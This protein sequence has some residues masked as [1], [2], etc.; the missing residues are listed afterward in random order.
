MRS[1]VGIPVVPAYSGTRKVRA[2]RMSRNH[3]KTPCCKQ[4]SAQ[5]VEL[6]DPR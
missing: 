1:T 2:G 6:G 4:H 5:V 3:G